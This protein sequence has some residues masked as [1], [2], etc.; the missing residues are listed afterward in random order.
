MDITSSESIMKTINCTKNIHN[1]TGTR[2]L[3]HH[4]KNISALNFCS[5]CLVKAGNP[6]K[7]PPFLGLFTYASSSV[8]CGNLPL[9]S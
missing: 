9:I 3:S 6:P 1:G 8:V 4:V 7:N 2:K 5:T